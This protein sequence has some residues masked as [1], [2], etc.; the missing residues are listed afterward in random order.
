SVP[1]YLLLNL[2][3][4][5]G[6][7]TVFVEYWTTCSEL[8]NGLRAGKTLIPSF[9][10]LLKKDSCCL[11][12]MTRGGQSPADIA[13]RVDAFRYVLT[14]RDQIITH[15]DVENFCRFELGNK[16]IKIKVCH[17]V[18]VSPKPKEGLV[19]TIDIHLTPSPGYER[20][21]TDIQGDLLISL[22][23]KSPDSFNYRVVIKN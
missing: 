13:G 2:P 15:E 4:N 14:T 21:V 8:A 17:G 12:N 6:N 19:R 11:L 1:D 5:D 10:A 18:A 23:R 9:S 20:I 3:K 7:D 16:I 22:H